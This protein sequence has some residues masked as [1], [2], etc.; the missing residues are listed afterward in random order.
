VARA[1]RAGAVLWPLL[2]LAAAPWEE[3]GQLVLLLLVHTAHFGWLARSGLRRAGASLSALAFNGAMVAAFFA[4]GWHGAQDLALPAG[5]SVMALSYAFRD[6]LGREA[7][8]KLR[9]VAMTAV[10]GAAAWRPLTFTTTWGLG[11]CVVVCVA[12]VAAGAALRIR[13]FVMLGTAFLVTSVLATLVRQGL[14]E[15][16]LGAALL[17]LLGL[18][19]VGFMVLFTTRRAELRERVD[20]LQRF[21]GT[22][23]A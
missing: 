1:L 2:G 10:Y 5:L 19:V 8:V 17:A 14:A 16:R 13:S 22:W 11:F 15:P 9:A 3:P 7:Q 12:G 20:A 6:E 4:T 18:A 23:E 21:L